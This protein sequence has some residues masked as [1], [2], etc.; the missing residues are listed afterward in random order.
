MGYYSDLAIEGTYHED[1]S[2]PS[3]GLQLKWRI[4]DLQSRLECI[5]S[6]NYEITAHSFISCRFSRNYLAYT[7]LEYFS[8]EF[9]TMEI[10]VMLKKIWQQWKPKKLNCVRSK[11]AK[12]IQRSIC[13][14]L[15]FGIFFKPE[16]S[17]LLDMKK[18]WKQRRK[19]QT[20]EKKNDSPYIRI[21]GSINIKIKQK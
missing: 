4:E 6:G 9:D 12:S 21:V 15:L 7:L 10:L 19:A 1:N 16:S 8:R 14:N 18:S 20:L 3:H 13:G 11:I 2:Y 5:S 17:H